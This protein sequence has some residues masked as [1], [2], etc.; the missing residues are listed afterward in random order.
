MNY[1]KM[2]MRKQS[3]R[4]LFNT[5]RDTVKLKIFKRFGG[6]ENKVAVPSSS[7]QLT[8]IKLNK[9]SILYEINGGLVSKNNWS[10]AQ[11]AFD[12]LS[13]QLGTL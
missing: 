11:S 3:S 5:R 13:R 4:A 9:A 6:C 1:G 8:T 7:P 12:F 2:M 10:K